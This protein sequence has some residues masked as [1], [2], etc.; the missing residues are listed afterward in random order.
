MIR[1]RTLL[2]LLLVLGAATLAGCASTRNAG[3]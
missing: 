3:P 2:P 1:F